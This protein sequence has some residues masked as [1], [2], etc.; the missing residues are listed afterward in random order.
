M[1][2]STN[3]PTS[4]ITV[5]VILAKCDTQHPGVECWLTVED[6]GGDISCKIEVVKL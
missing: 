2:R 3:L 5:T 1:Y 6:E 4:I